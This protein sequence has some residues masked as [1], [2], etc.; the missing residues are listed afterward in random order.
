MNNLNP[1]VV[2]EVGYT[3]HLE[4]IARGE[5]M[6]RLLSDIPSRRPIRIALAS[7]LVSVAHRLAPSLDRY[8]PAEAGRA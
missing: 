5:A 4:R 3:L 8:V 6:A 1:S 2:F 7:V